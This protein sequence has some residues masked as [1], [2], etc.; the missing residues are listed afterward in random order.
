MQPQLFSH[1][2]E[3]TLG[4]ICFLT[5][6]HTDWHSQSEF[7]LPHWGCEGDVSVALASLFLSHWRHVQRQH[8]LAPSSTMLPLSA[9]SPHLDSPHRHLLSSSAACLRLAICL[10]L[11]LDTLS[12]QDA[13][14]HAKTQCVNGRPFL[15]MSLL[16][17]NLPL[18]YHTAARR[19]SSPAV[20]PN[21]NWGNS[22]LASGIARPRCPF[23]LWPCCLLHQF[24]LHLLIQ[25]FLWL[26][27]VMTTILVI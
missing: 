3:Q 24:N 11:L 2:H 18:H 21:G 9:T 15:H 26:A 4:S 16:I 1:T 25:L 19:S 27:I 8:T 6:M 17:V 14:T 5:H 20:C 10:H 23:Q 7:G 13:Y 12:C 22:V